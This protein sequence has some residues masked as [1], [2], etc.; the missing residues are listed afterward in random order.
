MKSSSLNTDVPKIQMKV[1]FMA[2]S[3]EYQDRLELDGITRFFHR[4]LTLFGL[5][6]SITGSG[7]GFP[8]ISVN[9]N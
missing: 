2:Q 1:S 7:S 3:P 8:M 6:A 9:I 4:G 5:L